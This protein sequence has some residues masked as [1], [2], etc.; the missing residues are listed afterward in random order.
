MA[1]GFIA[2]LAAGAGFFLYRQ[3][4]EEQVK[5]VARRKFTFKMES[6]TADIAEMV[7]RRLRAMGKPSGDGNAARRQAQESERGF[8]QACTACASSEACERDRLNI[9]AGRGSETYN[10]CQ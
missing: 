3:H 5:E 1:I 7:D 4:V 10:P 6:E 2:L 9:L 8:V